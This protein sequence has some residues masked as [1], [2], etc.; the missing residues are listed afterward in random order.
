M[1]LSFFLSFLLIAL[2]QVPHALYTQQIE[3]GAKA[4]GNVSNQHYN[5]KG[6]ASS[7]LDDTWQKRKVGFK[8]GVFADVLLSKQLFFSPAILF[9]QKGFTDN[10]QY[11]DEQGSLIDAKNTV[12]VNYLSVDLP[13]KV[14]MWT[15]KISPYLSAGP[16]IDFL[17]NHRTKDYLGFDFYKDIFT[18]SRK[19]NVG[20]VVAVGAEFPIS[21][22]LIS[23]LELE[24]NPDLTPAYKNESLSIKNS[25][26]AINTGIRF[27][28]RN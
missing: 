8:A 12:R 7:V 21:G 24:Y 1:K 20:A 27:G 5:Y 17:L 2:L 10:L 11:T 4:G 25:L 22:K 16:R 18:N 28:K 6:Q 26:I 23:F 13:V 3:F 19:V 14:K 15:G 9:N